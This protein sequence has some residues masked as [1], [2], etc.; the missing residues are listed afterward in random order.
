MKPRVIPRTHSLAHV[1]GATKGKVPEWRNGRIVPGEC[2]R[3]YGCVVAPVVRRE[4]AAEKEIKRKQEGGL[5]AGPE[6]GGWPTAA[7][8][9]SQQSALSGSHFKPPPLAEVLTQRPYAAKEDSNGIEPQPIQNDQG[10]DG[11]VT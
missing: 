10:S 1:R 7:T 4:T 2:L 11:D 5:L 9:G 3:V 8:G 6:T